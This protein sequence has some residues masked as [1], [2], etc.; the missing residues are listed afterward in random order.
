MERIRVASA[1]VSFG[2]YTCDA[3]VLGAGAML[4]AMRDA[5][6]DGTDSGPIGYFGT[7]DLLRERLSARGLALA[8]GWIDLRY[9]EEEGFIA[10][11]GALE[12]AL[13][14]F[15]AVTVTQPDTL[16][17]ALSATLFS[18]VSAALSTGASTGAR[19]APRPTLAC[20]PNPARFAAPG[21]PVD[22][23]LKRTDWPSFAARIQ[24]AADRCRDRGLEP[25]FHHHL[26]TDV[27]TPDEIERLL[28]LTDVS[29][30][31]DTGHLT[32]G[33]GD[34]LT[35]LRDW[36]PRIRQIHIKDADRA[37]LARTRAAHGD[38]WALVAAGGFPALG[39][40][41]L[42][43]PAI[44]AE[45]RRIGYEGWIVVE[46]D[47]PATGQDISAALADQRANREALRA[48]GL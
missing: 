46:Q 28:E 7:G 38:L 29:L 14:V 10:D 11:L 24:R 48:V 1:P 41:D 37:V 34:P 47:V 4:D 44:A 32:L 6:Y 20:P 19:F 5:G 18:A 22:P 17:G 42:D 43:L 35:A 31:L 23:A 25:V 8:G 33:G 15:A 16:P 21:A 39:H 12:A 9:G 26:G 30:C 2:V 45:I 27:E 3:D 13:D 40:G 36:A